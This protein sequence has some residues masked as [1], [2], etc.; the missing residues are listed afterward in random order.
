MTTYRKGLKSKSSD[1]LA[2]VKEFYDR[3]Q[4]R[5]TAGLAI[6]GEFIPEDDKRILSFEAIEE[7]LDI[8]SYLSMCEEKH[9]SLRPR[10]Q[11]IR[12]NTILLYGELK[13]LEESERTQGKAGTK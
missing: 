1:N 10:I 8:G 2:L 7:C 5:I 12:A 9:P 4:A 3:Y 6:Y 11:R 13:S